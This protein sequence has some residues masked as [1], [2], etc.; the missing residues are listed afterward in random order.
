MKKVILITNSWYTHIPAFVD[1][2]DNIEIVNVDDYDPDFSYNSESAYAWLNKFEADT[3]IMIQ[4]S[5]LAE[6]RKRLQI[7]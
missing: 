5:S 2:L 6:Y 7:P 1:N 3:F 4:E